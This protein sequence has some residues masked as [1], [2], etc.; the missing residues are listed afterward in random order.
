MDIL[1]Q[2]RKWRENNEY[3]KIIDALEALPIEEC[4]PELDIE[5]VRAYSNPET[6]SNRGLL[7]KAIALLKSH[8]NYFAGDYDW[9]FLM[10]Y[11]YFHL[12]QEGR[13]LRYF[14]NA[15]EARSGD[16]DTKSLIEPLIEECKK[17]IALPCF[18]GCFRERTEAAWE[19]FSDIEAQ[20]RRMMDE[21]KG[22]TR[23]AEI[24]VKMEEILNRVFDEISF[25]VGM[26]GEKY[27]LILTSEG[28][29]VRL[30]ELCYFRRHAP[31]EV[32]EHWNI[33]VGRQPL[34]NIGLRVDD[35]WY[36][37]G[38]DVQIWLEE[39]G[40]NSFAIFAYCEKL[41]PLLRES[42]DRGWWMIINLIDQ[43]LGEIP[44]MRY[45]DSIDVLTEPKAEPSIPLSRLLDKLKEQVMEFSTDPESYLESYIGYE[46]DSERDPE[47]DWRLDV[48][49]GI[50]NCFPLINGYLNAD[51]D[52]MD[53][54]HADG[55]VAGFLCYPLDTLWEEEG[56]QKIFDFRGKLEKALITGNDPEALIL[57]GGATGFY[58]GYVDFIAWDIRTVLRMAKEFFANSDIPWACFHTFRREAGT[59]NLK[60]P[61][62]EKTDN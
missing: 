5:L 13:G 20:L 58:C 16:E 35:G 22:H 41:L 52:F 57:T 17:E 47:A 3:W 21:D 54:L 62:G 28:D 8:E 48:M 45:I 26:G 61:S 40:E 18:S 43:M 7:K 49:T 55:A 44:R 32:L 12:D 51:N 6:V 29:K 11:S 4:T 1:T 24:M 2:C 15:L 53:D 42:E 59:V 46:I 39:Q 50:T 23:Y 34:R 60:M 9:N 19:T 25:E 31:K 37:S 14:E 33:V 10:G 38:E 30:F 56:M 27:E 36:I